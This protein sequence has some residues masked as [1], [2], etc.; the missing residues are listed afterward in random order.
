M[1]EGTGNGSWNSG[2]SSYAFTRV[3]SGKLPY[4]GL[5]DFPSFKLRRLTTSYAFTR[6]P[7]WSPNGATLAA[8]AGR[9][10]QADGW[11][12]SGTLEYTR[13]LLF[14]YRGKVKKSI[15]I[16]LYKSRHETN[17]ASRL[18]WSPDSRR[19]A[20]IDQDAEGGGPLRFVDIVKGR[21]TPVQGARVASS[22]MS[23]V[24]RWLLYSGS[25]WKS[26]QEG[27]A[28]V[29]AV[30]PTL[31]HRFHTIVSSQRNVYYRI[32]SAQSRKHGKF[33]II[34]ERDDMGPSSNELW[35]GVVKPYPK[36]VR[37]VAIFRSTPL[38]SSTSLTATIPSSARHLW[39]LTQN[40]R[41]VSAVPVD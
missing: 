16:R 2:S 25:T 17:V 13:I 20:F 27:P 33:A 8:Y 31:P 23:W 39:I 22:V 36:L 11:P 3:A 34:L 12:L 6:G 5:L 19:I 32:Q 41:S 26:T 28:G 14:D 1:G 4:I 40:G 35:T 30:T 38:G 9:Q 37:K 21:V 18:T 15:P 7:V 10:R 29:V 24:G